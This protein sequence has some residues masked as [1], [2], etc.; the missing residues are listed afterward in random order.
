MQ[1]M[2]MVK[3]TRESEAGVMPSEQLLT[4]MGKFNEELVKAGILLSAAGLHPS[5]TG[6][7]VRFSGR[8]R[9]VIDGPFA[10]TKELVAG[11]WLWQVKSL[12]EAIAWV[13]RCPNPMESE[14]E[15]EIRPLF[16]PEDFGPA[17]TPELQQQEARMRAEMQGYALEPPRFEDGRELLIA[18]L[19]QSYTFETRSQIPAQ[20]AR[21]APQ[22]GTIPGQVGAASYGVCWNY[23]PGSG[24]DYL[25]GV[26]VKPSAQLPGTLSQVRIPAGRYAVFTHRQHVSTIPQTLDAIWKKWLPN[27]GYQA[28]DAPCFERYDERFDP[29]SGMGGFEIWVALKP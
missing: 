22:M 7:R 5:A 13:K 27:S 10:E 12:E 19:N 24:F 28:A 23:K 16:A 1:V 8:D 18:G 25:S 29:R 14:G 9:T 21:F 6:A 11:F 3:A 15:I 4:E 20:W 17:L 26:E 2:V